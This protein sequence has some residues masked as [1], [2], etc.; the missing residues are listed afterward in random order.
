ME[1]RVEVRE[2]VEVMEGEGGGD[3]G[4]VEVMEGE[5]KDIRWLI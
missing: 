3:G 5:N 4:R 2:R 1:G